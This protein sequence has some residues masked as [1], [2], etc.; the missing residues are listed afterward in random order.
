MGGQ[1]SAAD[2]LKKQQQDLTTRLREQLSVLPG[3]VVA[4]SAGV[5]ST[6]LL[7]ACCEVLGAR[8]VAV[9][10]DS[11]SLPRSELQEARELSAALGWF[12]R[13][14]RAARA[15]RHSKVEADAIAALWVWAQESELE[16][17]TRIF[18]AAR[19][20]DSVLSAA[21]PPPSCSPSL[22]A[23]PADPPAPSAPPATPPQPVRPLLSQLQ[24][25]SQPANPASQPASTLHFENIYFV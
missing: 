23:A 10:A 21:P 19:E 13:A 11:P 2:D 17:L 20:L 25:G 3:A 15:V 7:H 18:T 9:T 22:P 16:Q 24:Q 5:D 8:V 12:G 4:F 14:L 6:A 1:I